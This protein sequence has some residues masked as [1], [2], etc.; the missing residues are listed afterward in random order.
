MKYTRRPRSIVPTILEWIAM[1][2]QV[3]VASIEM[4]RIPDFD[5]N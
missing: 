1:E 4:I 5:S 3:V 2:D